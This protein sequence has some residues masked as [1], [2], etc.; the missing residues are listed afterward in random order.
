MRRTGR[1]RFL[2][3]AT[4]GVVR[5]PAARNAA[6]LGV[7]M[8]R[9][10]TEVEVVTDLA[11]TSEAAEQLQAFLRGPRFSKYARFIFAALG[12]V[13]W[14]GGF[15]AAS[16]AF[17]AEQEQAKANELIERWLEEHEQ[18]IK[19]LDDTLGSMVSRLEELGEQVDERMQDEGYLGLVRHGFRI[20]DEAP[21][22][23]KREYIRRVL[24]SAGS[25]KLCLDDVVRLFLDWNERYHEAHFH[26]IRVIYH[27]EGCT[28][29]SSGTRST[30]SGFARTSPMPI[31]SSC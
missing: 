8:S 16:A 9:E 4:A 6:T 13:P 3:V 21:T 25:T 12:S 15:L 28:R 20:W 2:G 5:E 23:E 31:S 1:R 17:H 27:H 7:E 18:K 22:E 11:E 26:V 30:G 29:A 10:D 24:T 19:N 14:V